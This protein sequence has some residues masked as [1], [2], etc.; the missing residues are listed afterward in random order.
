MSLR[1]VVISG[2]SGTGKST[3]LKILFN[4]FENTF[5]FSIS[6]TTR[7]PRP[8]EQDGIDYHFSSR[9]AMRKEIEEGKFLE[10]AEFSGNLY[11]TSRAAVQKVLDSDRICVLDVEEQGVRSIK[12]TDLDALYIF[13]KPPSLDTLR[14]RLRNR[15]TE[16]DESLKKRM[17]TALSAIKFSETRGV[18]DV[19]IINDDLNAAYQRLESFLIENM[20]TLAGY[21]KS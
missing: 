18:Y 2:P 15:G 21:R 9:E 5:G 8:K 19:I 17:D 1:P 16:T 10:H 11:G 12:S 13:I 7:S 3:L 6:H 14:E 4:T 20:P